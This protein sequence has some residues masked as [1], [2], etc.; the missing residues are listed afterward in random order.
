MIQ[1]RARIRVVQLIIA[2]LLMATGCGR[3]YGPGP[4]F[5]VNVHVPNNPKTYGL[6]SD[7]GIG[8][9]RVDFNWLTFEPR[10]DEFDWTIWD[11]VVAK[12]NEH[13]LMIFATV[14]YSPSWAT[15][16]SEW[17]GVP[18]DPSDWYDAVYQAVSRYKD[19]VQYWGMWNEPNLPHF[20]E[21]TRQQ[22]IDIILKNGAEALRAANPHAKVCAPGLAHLQHGQRDWYLWLKECI[23]QA[24]DQ[25]DVVTHNVYDKQGSEFVTAK[26]DD[27][28]PLSEDPVSRDRRTLA[29]D[30]TVWSDERVPSVKEVLQYTGWLG[31]PFWITE[32]GLKYDYGPGV[33]ASY[34][35]DLL[36]TWF[37]QDKQRDWIEKIFFYDFEQDP[38]S[39]QLWG[40]TESDLTP[41]AHYWA[42]KY[43]IYNADR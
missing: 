33:V 8:W 26:L 1:S 40:M 28:H 35:T 9:I 21:G 3:D 38:N 23:E 4:R 7:A 13:N 22:Y 27:S 43:F 31:R 24:G 34:Y 32:T 14:A 42:Y 2:T 12:A 18:C 16:G 20:W 5:G 41:R 17:K 19:S 15:D 37:T 39:D 10:Q 30:P 11:R 29:H 25:I 6:V 36:E